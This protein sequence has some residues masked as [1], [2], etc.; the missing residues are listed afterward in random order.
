MSIT[1]ANSVYTL[2][3]DTIFPQPVTL[4]K[5]AVDDAF[6]TTV[7][8]VG[9]VQMGVD[10]QMSG[11]FTFVEIPQEISFIAD[12]PSVL[13]FDQWWQAELQAKDVYPATG[14]IQLPSTKTKWSMTNGILVSYS[15]I[16]DAKRVLQPRRFGITWQSAVSQPI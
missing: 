3:I 16:P 15:P 10:G 7:L 8:R 5:Y 13:I 9:E 4:Q 6:T 1:S 12:S 11:G 14:T 2:S